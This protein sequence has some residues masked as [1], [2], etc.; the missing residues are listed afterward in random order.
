[1]LVLSIASIYH[2]NMDTD[3]FNYN[4]SHN[5]EWTVATALDKIEESVTAEKPFFLYFT[6]TCPHSP[7]NEEALA[8][9]MRNTPAG[10]LD[11]DPVTSMPARA[12]V[13]DRASAYN[14]TIY[15]DSSIGTIWIDDALGGLMD[16]IESLGELNNTIF[17]VTMDHGQLAKNELYEGGTRVALFVMGP[18]VRH[19]EDISYAVSNIDLVPTILEA[20]GL[21]NVFSNYSTDG[22]S[23]WPSVTENG[24]TTALEQRDC[25]ISE[26]EYD[27]SVV[28]AREWKDTG[29]IGYSTMKY[30]SN[31]DTDESVVS[32]NDYPY[33]NMMN[34]LYNITVDNTEQVS[35]VDDMAYISTLNFLQELIEAH[36]VYTGA[37]NMSPTY[38]PS[39]SECAFTPIARLGDGK[40]QPLANQA[41]CNYDHGDCCEYTCLQHTDPDSLANCGVIQPYNCIDPDG[42]APPTSSPTLQSTPSHAPTSFVSLSDDPSSSPIE[43]SLTLSPTATPSSD[44]PGSSSGGEDTSETTLSTV[45]MIIVFVVV[46]VTLS[47]TVGGSIYYY[48]F[49]R[50]EHANDTTTEVGVGVTGGVVSRQRQHKLSRESEEVVIQGK[51]SE[52]EEGVVRPS[53]TL[54]TASPGSY[55]L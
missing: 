2:S 13:L 20:A 53:Y 49:C 45:E 47:V 28:C 46:I 40:C 55:D 30:I 23:W 33:S 27:R 44:N 18:E 9:S 35:L 39:T 37:P 42:T 26:I 36:D 41:S 32:T 7:S 19:I 6:P 22:I 48:Y 38:Q 1:M 3:D 21:S 14:D 51:N 54:V 16:G 52:E 15:H 25:I 31:F 24:N 50:D 4:F 5:L 43:A 10:V 17:I 29:Q 11:S 8:Y 12:T 34:Q